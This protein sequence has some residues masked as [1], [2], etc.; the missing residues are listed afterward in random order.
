MNNSFLPIKV[1]QSRRIPESFCEGVG[2]DLELGDELVLVGSDGREHRLRE[3]EGAVLL[4]RQ[5]GDGPA[6]LTDFHEVDARL[7]PVHRV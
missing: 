5:V 3:H 7:V 2:V 6:P 1:R 4:P